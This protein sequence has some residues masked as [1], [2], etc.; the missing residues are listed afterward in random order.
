MTLP[1]SNELYHL[2]NRLRGMQSELTDGA[3]HCAASDGGDVRE[4]AV[5]ALLSAAS[6]VARAAE[7]VSN[8]AFVIGGDEEYQHRCTRDALDEANNG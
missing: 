8:L 1:T 2:R 7:R 6:A 3:T 5:A 4:R